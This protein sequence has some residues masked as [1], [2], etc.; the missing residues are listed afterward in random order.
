MNHHSSIDRP[1]MDRFAHLDRP[2]FDEPDRRLAR[3]LL[4]DGAS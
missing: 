2:F 1:R 4:K 3:E